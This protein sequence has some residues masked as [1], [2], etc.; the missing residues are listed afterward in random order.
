MVWWHNWH[1]AKLLW[2]LLADY[3]IIFFFFLQFSSL[4]VPTFYFLWEIGKQ[5]HRHFTHLQDLLKPGAPFLQYNEWDM[6]SV[7][8]IAYGN[9][10]RITSTLT[11]VGKKGMGEVPSIGIS[12]PFVPTVANSAIPECKFLDIG[13]KKKK[14]KSKA[15]PISLSILHKLLYCKSSCIVS[16]LLLLHLPPCWISLLLSFPPKSFPKCSVSLFKPICW[17]PLNYPCPSNPQW[18]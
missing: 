5:N 16:P 12:Q 6:N 4:S 2:Q 9:I 11:S 13:K 14:G 8:K 10:M 15:S 3:K 17:I 18:V 1:Y 7:E